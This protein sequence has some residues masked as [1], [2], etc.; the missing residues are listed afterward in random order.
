MCSYYRSTD[1]NINGD[2]CKTA[3]LSTVTVR[4]ADA[5]SGGAEH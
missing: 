1:D 4:S 5:V 3:D 2:G